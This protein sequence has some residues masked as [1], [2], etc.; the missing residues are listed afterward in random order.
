NPQ[1]PTGAIMS[2]QSL[3]SIVEIARRNNI[4][5]LSDEVYRPTFHGIN[6]SSPSFPPSIL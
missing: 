1:N 4:I 5:V 2:K 6:P 3:E